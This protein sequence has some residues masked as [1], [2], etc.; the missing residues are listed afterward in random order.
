MLP[1]L[2]DLGILLIFLYYSNSSIILKI[3]NNSTIHFRGYMGDREECL[4]VASSHSFG[5]PNGHHRYPQLDVTVLPPSVT[6]SLLI[7]WQ[8]RGRDVET[9]F[10]G[11][12]M[13]MLLG[14]HMASKQYVCMYVCMYPFVHSFE[15]QGERQRHKH[16]EKQAPCEK[17]NVGLD[18]GNPR[19]M[20]WA[21]S[22][23]STTEPSR[24]PLKQC[25]KCLPWKQ[26]S[27]L[28]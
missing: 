14:S 24:R 18:P 15:T 3:V 13:G 6:F 23:R 5:E 28:G 26:D 11:T 16:W 4:P 1:F 10:L 19:I 2:G 22:R 27:G 17:P 25:L 9:N 21:K 8:I 12:K 7:P 20:P